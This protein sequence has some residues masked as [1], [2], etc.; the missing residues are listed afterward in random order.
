V[1]LAQKY[2]LNIANIRIGFAQGC[3]KS[4]K[5]TRYVVIPNP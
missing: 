4:A 1:V 3:G 5:N 2:G